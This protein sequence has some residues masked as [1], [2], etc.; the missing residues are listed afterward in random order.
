MKGE[1]GS[2]GPDLQ[3]RQGRHDGRAR[4]W[5]RMRVGAPRQRRPG[6]VLD[7]LVLAPGPYEWVG[8]DL[9]TGALVRARRPAPDGRPPL[10]GGWRQ[11]DIA[12]FVLGTDDEPPDPSRPEAIVCAE[13]PQR[14][15]RLRR[16]AV[17]RV[18][19][20]LVPPERPGAALLGTHGPSIPFV[21]LDGSSP[22]VMLVAVAHRSLEVFAGPGEAVELAFA[23]SGARHQLPVH[24]PRLRAAALE[25]QPRPLSAG[26]LAAAAGGRVSV[27]VVGLGPVRGGHVPKVVLAALPA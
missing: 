24:D 22:S 2:P 5:R 21:D 3:P 13:A 25:S 12:R 7:C 6:A 20:R 8:I 10:G 19:R 27:L 15:G 16:R 1:P 4:S 18:L 11:F 14:L 17:R 23:W 9:A 26:R